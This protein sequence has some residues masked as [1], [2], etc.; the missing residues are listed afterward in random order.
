MYTRNSRIQ[1]LII[2]QVAYEG[3]L[4]QLVR[5]PALQ[6]GGRRFESCTA[7]QIKS[8]TYMGRIFCSWSDCGENCGYPASS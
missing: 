7:H 5:A 8:M 1:A 3:R 4:A 6:A 2:F